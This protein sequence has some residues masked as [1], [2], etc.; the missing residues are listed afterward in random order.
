[1][2]GASAASDVTLTSF[3]VPREILLFSEEDIAVTGEVKFTILRV[4]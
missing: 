4:S 2:T 1:M 3:K